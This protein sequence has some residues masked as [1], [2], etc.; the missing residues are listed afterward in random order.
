MDRSG[1]LAESPPIGSSAT[2][3][4]E[5]AL[6]L[7]H[8][9]HHRSRPGE[10]KAGL[11]RPRTNPP[12]WPFPVGVVGRRDLLLGV[13][14]DRFVQAI[15]SQE[16]YMKKPKPRKE[17]LPVDKRPPI[18]DAQI[19]QTLSLLNRGARPIDIAKELNVPAQTIYNVRQRY[20][21]IKLDDG[22]YWYKYL[23]V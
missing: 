18:K 23:G 13:E 2:I 5:L 10:P 4:F 6:G 16:A 20:R 12:L 11:L 15:R 9:L 19:M 21:R 14:M 17:N 7:H 1:V 8:A 22:T 3:E